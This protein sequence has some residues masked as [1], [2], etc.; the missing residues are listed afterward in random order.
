MARP[1]HYPTGGEYRDL[2]SRTDRCFDDPALVGGRPEYDP[3]GMPR[4]ISGN[5]ASIFALTGTDGRRWALKCFTR[6]VPEQNLRYRRISEALA[7]RDY[8]WR[9]AFEYLPTGLISG[10]GR[11]PLLKMKWVDAQGLLA[12]MDRHWQEPARIAAIAAQFAQIA[13]DLA[14]A[15]LAHGDLQHGNLLVT[16]DHV[17]KLV[18]YDGM[19]VPRLRSLSAAEVGHP[20]YQSPRRTLRDWGPQLD[21]FS[22]WTIYASLAAVVIDPS[23]WPR[24]HIAGEEALLF[25]RADFEELFSSRPLSELSHSKNAALEAVAR[26]VTSL[27]G[28]PLRDLPSLDP[29]A[30]GVAEQYRDKV[31]SA[32]P[33]AATSQSSSSGTRTS[34]AS[35]S[36]DALAAS[37]D[38][39]AT[40]ELSGWMTTH[41]PLLPPASFTGSRWRIRAVTALSVLVAVGLGMLAGPAAV[42]GLVFYLIAGGA[43]YRSTSERRAKTRRLRA[44]SDR[45]RERDRAVKHLSLLLERRAPMGAR[46]EAMCRVSAVDRDPDTRLATIATRHAR[47]E[48][49]ERNAAE[50]AL[51]SLRTEQLNV[52]LAT[53]EIVRAGIEGLDEAGLAALS[54]GGIRTAADFLG[55]VTE[56]ASTTGGAVEL[57]FHRVDGTDVI[58]PGIDQATASRVEAWRRQVAVEATSALPTELPGD[59]AAAIHAKYRPE[60]DELD[61]AVRVS[62]L[63][64]E[65][66]GEPAPFSAETTSAELTHGPGDVGPDRRDH[67]DDEVTEAKCRL[68]ETTEHRDLAKREFAALRRITFGRYLARTFRG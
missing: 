30:V 60:L 35:D 3:H 53:H 37:G 9:V 26:A 63:G 65:A 55:I 2:L 18:D 8:P 54:S 40:D 50:S 13:T 51:Q 36:G 44:L 29:S 4:A 67:L 28:Q 1:V 56:P 38:E 5:F 47:V 32:E 33:V 45:D 12:Y 14:D 39:R 66:L 6:P 23:L 46:L 16:D 41:L 59:L 20:N 43:L 10:E 15:G 11:Y 61:E 64:S 25:R 22:A 31:R 68:A 21:N 24:L 17:L 58:F 57:A 19:Y 62:S 48:A 34:G 27:C 7:V 42:G 49:S 52:D